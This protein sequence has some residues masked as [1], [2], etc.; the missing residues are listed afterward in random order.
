MTA[1]DV[2]GLLRERHRE[3]LI[4]FE[5][6]TG[7]YGGSALRFDAWATQ[8]S[9]AH[10]AVHGYE[11]K[12]TRADFLADQKMTGYLPY[13]NCMWLVCP[14]DVL[15]VNEV[16]AEFG[17]LVVASTG[18][19]LIVRK[20]APHRPMDDAKARAIYRTL[21][22]TRA[23]LSGNP[24]RGPVDDVRDWL[25][26]REIDRE[27]GRALSKRL[28]DRYGMDVLAVKDEQ[29]A[30]KVRMDKY[31][32]LRAL[33]TRLGFDDS[34]V[35]RA[36]VHTLVGAVARA[37]QATKEFKLPDVLAEVTRSLA[38]LHQEAQAAERVLRAAS[39]RLQKELAGAGES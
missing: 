38:S 9:H 21:L 26:G 16:P 20:K 19:R 25:A 14:P 27:H 17:L 3:D 10:P 32:E 23:R 39:E 8:R 31:D 36:P 1:A 12:V 22:V 6:A 2:R 28:A 35:A 7:A 5:L 18:R 11:I 34:G 33:L 30:L 24:N 4:A 29:R 37:V 15:D 13:C